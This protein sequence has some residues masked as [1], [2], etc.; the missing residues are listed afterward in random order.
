MIFSF[1]G[2]LSK[3]GKMV[4]ICNRCIM[5][6]FVLV[7]TFS[8]CANGMLHKSL[9][10]GFY[11]NN[12]NNKKND[13]YTGKLVHQNEFTAINQGPVNLIPRV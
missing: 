8:S 1:A 13:I 5:V 12:S 6:G 11:L 9:T 4:S 10:L 7:V 3:M 2:E